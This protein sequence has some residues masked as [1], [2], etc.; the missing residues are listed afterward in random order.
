MAAEGGSAREK[1]ETLRQRAAEAR[2]KADRM[3]ASA[4]RWEAGVLGEERVAAAL[5]PLEGEHCRVLHDRLLY[6]RQSRVNL[7]HIV[8]SVAGNYLIDAKNWSGLVTA[9]EGGL[10]QRIPTGHWVLDG[11]VDNV[12]RMAAQME[13]GT[14]S[15]IE[16]VI[17]L[18]GE[19]AA[20][21][22]EPK[23]VRGV[24]IVPVGQLAQWLLAQ[25]RKPDPVD[26]DAELARM[27][28]CFPSATDPAYLSSAPMLSGFASTGRGSARPAPV[29]S[30]PA[31]P[32]HGTGRSRRAVGLPAVSL[33]AVS[34]PARGFR[35]RGLRRS[36]GV[37]LTV[38]LIL[39]L[40]TPAGLRLWRSG[41]DA[42]G[43]LF[44]QQVSSATKPAAKA[45]VP[46]CTAVTDAVV[47][48]AVGHKV[49]RYVNGAADVCTWG[50]V[51]RPNPTAPGSLRIAT[52]WTAKNGGYPVGKG[53]RFTQTATSQVLTV[54]QRAAVPG[55]TAAPAS[56]TQPMVLVLTWRS[57]PVSSAQARKA[58]TLLAGEVAKHLPTGP[59]ATRIVR[60]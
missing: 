53:A 11:K 36:A 29:R 7:D 44:A 56:I 5:A 52:G 14:S 48:E 20:E 1:A 60:R 49:Y 31:P 17:C 22:G 58:V 37:L 23:V 27:A 57:S 32:K 59:G 42:A 45:W 19:H 30:K 50:F 43:N 51:P 13:T 16:P 39:S 9:E 25:P 3:E 10:R 15:V 54:P 8:V 38:A 24:Y 4:G 41:A 33:P 6:P 47:A 2:L 35:A 18:A 28:A 34:L 21:F 26:L 12:R 55:S 40:I 46:P